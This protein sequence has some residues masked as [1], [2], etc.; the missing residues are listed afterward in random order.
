MVVKRRGGETLVTFSEEARATLVAREALVTYA[1]R[2]F[3]TLE[4][5]ET[6]AAREAL[7]YVRGKGDP[8]SQGGLAQ[9]WHRRG[10]PRWSRQRC[11][12]LCDLRQTRAR[13]IV[14]EATAIKSLDGY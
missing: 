2:L 4:A 9:A 13:S 14:A 11:V 3:V 8:R 1:G 7:C 5:R 12:S 10:D 6:L